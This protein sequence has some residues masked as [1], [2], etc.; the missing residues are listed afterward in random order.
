MPSIFYEK[1]LVALLES[2]RVKKAALS[3]NYGDRHMDASDM[4]HRA[5]DMIIDRVPDTEYGQVKWIRGSGFDA[6]VAA[7]PHG[8]VKMFTL[9]TPQQI[10]AKWRLL[11]TGDRS[12]LGE[13]VGTFTIKEAIEI[14]KDPLLAESVLS[15]ISAKTLRSYIP[16]AR[17]DNEA[18]RK[19]IKKKGQTPWAKSS[20]QDFD[21]DEQKKF[22]NRDRSI[23]AAVSKVVKKDPKS[24]ASQ[25]TGKYPLDGSGSG[26]RSY[27]ESANLDIIKKLAG[28][29]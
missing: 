2:A 22:A 15:E 21:S 16:K 17:D 9:G 29:K 8:S 6:I 23:S 24:T 7:T 26:N 20:I 3:E 28:L 19:S 12:V 25:R 1:Q 18:R 10:S 14:L 11:K 27:S 4:P 5:P 13:S